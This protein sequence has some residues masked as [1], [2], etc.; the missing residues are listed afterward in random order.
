M[1]VPSLTANSPSSGFIAWAS[2]T[3]QYNGSAYPVTGSNTNS[4]FTAWLYNA[5][6]PVVVFNNNP[7]TNDAVN[8]STTTL[9]AGSS[10]T[11]GPD[12]LL[13][14]VN[15]SGV[16]INVQ[17]ASMLDGDLI[18]TG[19]VT[20]NAIATNTIVASNIA[21]GAITTTQIAANT[22]VAGNI[23]AGTI[24]ATQIAA[25]T[26][27][28]TQIAAGAIGA[29]SLTVGTLS[30]NLILNSMFESVDPSGNI[31]PWLGN[32]LSGSTATPVGSS[33]SPVIDGGR[34]GAI[35]VTA[36]LTGDLTSQAFPVTPGHTMYV[37]SY[38]AGSAINV[39]S[40]IALVFGTTQTFT[41]SGFV[42][43]TPA[44]PTNV[45]VQD[46][47]GN[48]QTG[49]SSSTAAGRVNIVNAWPCATA[50][51]IY[52]GQ[53]QFVVPALAQWARLALVGVGGTAGV[54]YV[55]DA[56]VDDV[57]L[58]A[59]IGNGQ[60]TAN[61]I[62]AN[63]ITASQ[64]AA[65]TITTTQIAANTIMAGNI[66]AGAITTAT[67]AAGAVTAT[68]IAANTITTSQLSA[69]AINGMT[70]TGSTIE[71]SSTVGNG[72][73]SSAGVIIDTSGL[74]AY[75]ANSSTA[76]VNIVASTGAFTATGTIQT[77]SPLSVGG[78]TQ[79]VLMSSSVAD[80]VQFYTGDTGETG[81]GF[82]AS[83]IVGSGTSR[84]PRTTISSPQLN[85]KNTAFI[86]MKG[87]AFTSGTGDQITLDAT[88]VR[89][90][91]SSG[92]WSVPLGTQ[93]SF[94]A[95]AAPAFTAIGTTEQT[96]YGT[97]AIGSFS[98]V[99]GRRYRLT[100]RGTLTASAASTS[101]VSQIRL[102]L[103]GGS[104]NSFLTIDTPLT[105]TAA[106]TFNGSCI[107]F[108]GDTDFAVG[109]LSFNLTQQC[110]AASPTVT[111]AYTAGAFSTNVQI[112]VE[113]IG[114]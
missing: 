17:A 11:L 70:I 50:N 87:A 94:R 31:T 53:G 99:N 23:A 58:S 47:S 83:G 34:S 84:Q 12:D 45:V 80:R 107:M 62:A 15:R 4:I 30:D 9:W 48:I 43:A 111:T 69:T 26:I 82:L 104:T 68:Q 13:L 39:K 75:P 19:T 95:S 78:S 38:F 79:G 96:I 7:P 35:T 92:S 86:E 102:R 65:S 33:T 52:M 37:N 16:P 112:T 114:Q 60:I 41:N 46:L 59:F 98:V 113:D 103:N 110:S 89:V 29:A 49:V 55:D 18:V 76:S 32:W 44:T 72:T 56:E 101:V 63:T 109:S 57:I 77:A 2:F 21:A 22:I 106:R 105:S 36:S 5:G 51:V 73:A 14:F 40:T 100:V 85:S 93:L 74:R 20:A 88:D 8:D 25:G 24:T 91:N 3:I 28:A 81:D 1:A 10:P 108:A 27:T 6:S 71:T 66:A 64:I 67:I 42:A 97:A 61:Q 90:T 54:L